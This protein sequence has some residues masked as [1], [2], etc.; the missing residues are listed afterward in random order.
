MDGQYS[1]IM[2]EIFA[3]RQDEW[4]H[5][6]RKFGFFLGKF[7]YLCDAY[8]DIEQDIKKGTPNPSRSLP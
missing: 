8:E 4:E 6:L 7:I 1:S 2:A 3:Y 5:S